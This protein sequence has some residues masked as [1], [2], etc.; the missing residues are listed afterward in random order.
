MKF[1][2]NICK[3]NILDII[4]L[5]DEHNLFIESIEQ[6]PINNDMMSIKVKFCIENE[7]KNIENFVKAVKENNE[8]NSCE[9]V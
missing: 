9:L 3:G 4:N 2:I 5:A 6:G 1:S 7:V 8:L